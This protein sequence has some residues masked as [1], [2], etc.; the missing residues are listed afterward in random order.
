VV[1]EVERLVLR[2]C[3]VHAFCGGLHRGLCRRDAPDRRR[4]AVLVDVR[5]RRVNVASGVGLDGRVDL[6]RDHDRL[7]G[8]VCRQFIGLKI[9]VVTG[10]GAAG[11][12]RRLGCLAFG[13][14][15]GD[16]SDRRLDQVFVEVLTH[17]HNP[18]P[19]GG[20]ASPSH[21]VFGIRV[22][23]PHRGMRFLGSRSLP[24]P[25][26]RPLQWARCASCCSMARI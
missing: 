14:R 25:G 8:R 20:P 16:T 18:Y 9:D 10:N 12:L 21:L 4:D 15:L 26:A 13:F 1:D 23:E 22:D 3:F 2:C 5:R 7:V 11:V 6:G 24:A 19:G 17:A